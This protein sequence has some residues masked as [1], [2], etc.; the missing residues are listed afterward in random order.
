MGVRL[1][2]SLLV[3]LLPAAALAYRPFDGTDADTAKNGEFEV[4][5]GP[6]G[7]LQGGARSVVAPALVL[8]LGLPGNRE[9]VLEG[10]E[11][12]DLGS[13]VTRRSL[14]DTALS[15]KQLWI[16]G[17]LQDAGGWGLAS[18]VGVLLP[19]VNGPPGVGGQ[20]AL[21]ASRR[22][23]PLSL[24]L[25][26]LVA[27]LR[28]HTLGLAASAILEGPEKWAVRPV[29]EMLVDSE[30]PLPFAWS[31]LLGF[32]APITSDVAIDGAVRAGRMGEVQVVELRFGVT[33]ALALWEG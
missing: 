31:G 32:I 23:G 1:A 33:F 13:V 3:L 7:L 21:I 2:T 11:R 14:V 5:L 24:H 19:T 22:F 26:G 17:D 6:G 12:L 4:E 20:A 8:N 29:A 9:L 10:K 16:P 27:L 28:T 15:W 18:E 25:N 30:N